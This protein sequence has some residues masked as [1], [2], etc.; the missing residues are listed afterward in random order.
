MPKWE[1]FEVNNRWFIQI[2]AYVNLNFL[3][4]NMENNYFDVEAKPVSRIQGIFTGV[5]NSTYGV[6]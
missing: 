4:N 3:L 6:T 5:Y 1:H 2:F